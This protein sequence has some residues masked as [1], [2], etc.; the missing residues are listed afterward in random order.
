M[1]TRNRNF[2]IE[3]LP[4]V[5]VAPEFHARSERLPML[6][7]SQ[8]ARGKRSPHAGHAP[9]RYRRRRVAKLLAWVTLRANAHI[10]KQ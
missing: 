5:N 1:K 9:S 7:K 8:A 4:F 3:S 6:G 10:N 2:V